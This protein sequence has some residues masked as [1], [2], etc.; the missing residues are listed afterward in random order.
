MATSNKEIVKMPGNLSIVPRRVGFR[1]GKDISRRKCHLV[2]MPK[3]P[4]SPGE[5]G[6]AVNK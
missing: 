6:D 4:F 2:H 5:A 1:E 3:Q